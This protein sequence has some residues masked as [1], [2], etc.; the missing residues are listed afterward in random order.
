M[1]Q[2]IM[3]TAP[4]KSQP[5]M[6]YKFV[7]C[8]IAEIS[9]YDAKRVRVSTLER[10][11]SAR[12]FVRISRTRRN[13]GFDHGR[14]AEYN[15][16]DYQARCFLVSWHASA[17]TCFETMGHTRGLSSFL[18]KPS[19]P[20]G[21]KFVSNSDDEA[22]YIRWMD[23]VAVRSPYKSKA[24]PRCRL[25]IRLI[26]KGINVHLLSCLDRHAATRSCLR[27]KRISIQDGRRCN[28]CSYQQ[29]W[30]SYA[31]SSPEHA[32]PSGD[33]LSLPSTR[34]FCQRQPEPCRDLSS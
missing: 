31:P 22:V 12:H 7:I 11:H 18:V 33:H 15:G 8:Q 14:A 32:T 2:N 1:K 19:L 13:E 21:L 4:E 20:D 10:Q 26:H 16:G 9:P 6:S 30:E 34:A 27:A 3:E 17:C 5:T 29:Y 28:R 25:T 23:I 24:F